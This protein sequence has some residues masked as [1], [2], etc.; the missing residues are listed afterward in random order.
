MSQA[1]DI[2]GFRNLRYS[3]DGR[4]LL[5]IGQFNVTKKTCIAL[6]GENGSG[7]STLMRIM[8]G[9]LQPDE[10]SVS[11]QGDTMPW[12][13]ARQRI[14]THVIYLH[15]QPYLF[16]RSVHD[17]LAYGMRCIG[18]TK[19]EIHERVKAMLEWANLQHLAE[20]NARLLSGGEKQRVAFARARILSPDVLLL[21]E[22]TVNMDE[23][24]RQQTWQMIERLREA[25]LSVIISTHEYDSISH[26]CDR[27]FYLESGALHC[28]MK[29]IS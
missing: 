12:S 23:T 11:F 7:K 22:P 9:L 28:R 29:H 26:L 10:A 3:I 13:R 2:I 8:A 21:D 15:Q 4:Q 17:N 16:D 19:S 14:R 25:N 5:N 27:H 1:N 6:S 20:R 24:A 18:A